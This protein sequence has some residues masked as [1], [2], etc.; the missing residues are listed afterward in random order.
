MHFVEIFSIR[1]ASEM[2]QSVF[3]QNIPNDMN[4]IIEILWNL[5]FFY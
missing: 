2:M 1:D 3:I 5:Y 4:E